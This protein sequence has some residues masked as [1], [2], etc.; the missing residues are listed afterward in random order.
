MVTWNIHHGADAWDHLDLGAV[1]AVLDACAAD[2]VALQEVDRHWDERSDDVD[3]TAWLS[4]RLGMHGIHGWTVRRVRRDR[5]ADGRHGNALLSRQPWTGRQ[6]TR[7]ADVAGVERRGVVAG[8]TR[9]P[10]GPVRFV[11]AHLST[12]HASLRSAEVGQLLT[13]VAKDRAAA[14][15]TPVVV[16]GDFNAEPR[17][18][19]LADLADTLT[20]AWRGSRQGLGDTAPAAK[21]WRRTDH[22]WVGGLTPV[23]AAVLRTEASDHLPVVVDL[24]TPDEPVG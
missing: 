16:A 3:Q 15:R 24:A 7:F 21:P 18:P 23:G 19:E 2:V 1:A 11:S 10:L 5:S 13:V 12:R 8:T 6:V 14:V 9:T 20:D 4:E 22:V 17:N